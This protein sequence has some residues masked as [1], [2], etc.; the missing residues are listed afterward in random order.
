LYLDDIEAITQIF[1]DVI[2][3]SLKVK[4]ANDPALPQ[5]DTKYEIGGEK[6]DSIED[7]VEEGGSSTRLQL[8]VRVRGSFESCALI[9]RSSFSQ[10]SVNSYGI[11]KAQRWGLHAKVSEV[12]NRRKMVVKNLLED[13]P[14]NVKFGAWIVVSLA[15]VFLSPA[16]SKPH[17]VI[18]D[19]IGD[20]YLVFAVVFALA[21]LELMLHASRVYFVRSRERM[22]ASKETTKKYLIRAGI[23]VLGVA[24]T[25]FV[26]YVFAKYI[27]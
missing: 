5:F 2:S 24:V 6:M 20:V 3:D 18:W 1:K 25:E 10:P 9:F 12:F 4:G 11:G 14:S 8:E 21:A 16:V 17:G 23:F 13:L 27:H 19:V 15:P 22:K 7:L 26:H